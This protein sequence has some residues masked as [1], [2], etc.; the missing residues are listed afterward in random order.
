LKEGFGVKKHFA[1][2]VCIISLLGTAQVSDA[3]IYEFDGNINSAP[4]KATMEI[5]VSTKLLTI[6]LQNTSPESAGPVISGFGIS[7]KNWAEIASG[8]KWNLL[9]GGNQES[10]A[11]WKRLTG[12]F[13]GNELY[14]FAD[15]AILDGLYNPNYKEINKSDYTTP[16]LLTV[17]FTSGDPVFN[18]SISPIIYIGNVG[19]ST[20]PYITGHLVTTP[21]PGT[22]LLLG[23]GLIGIAIVMREML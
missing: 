8:M 3:L 23:L 12:G 5:N 16:A 22:M 14:F 10:P 7:L 20:D 18:E 4:F 13:R 2:A 6:N 1:V 15:S 19:F 21:E 11:Q 17:S 9:A